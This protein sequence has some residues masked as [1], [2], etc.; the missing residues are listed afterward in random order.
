MSRSDDRGVP[1]HKYR[2]HEV[3]GDSGLMKFVLQEQADSHGTA[4]AEASW[5]TLSFEEVALLWRNSRDFAEMFMDSVKAVPFEAV[6]WESAPVTRT[7]MVRR[8]SAVIFV[9]SRLRVGCSCAMHHRQPREIIT[10]CVVRAHGWIMPKRQSPRNLYVISSYNT[11]NHGAVGPSERARCVVLR[12]R[13]IPRARLQ[14]LVEGQQGQASDLPSTYLVGWTCHLHEKAL[15]VAP[16]IQ[17]DSLLQCWLYIGGNPSAWRGWRWQ[18][19]L[20]QMELHIYRT[21]HVHRSFYFVET[22]AQVIEVPVD[23]AFC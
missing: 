16:T 1:P 5:R 21:A 17:L 8:E 3:D 14:P 2:A 7:T 10:V 18:D 20:V 11:V 12:V 19:D 4:A 15:C 9:G 6:F 22:R 23:R 13:N